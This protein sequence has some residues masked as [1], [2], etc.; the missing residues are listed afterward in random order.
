M[1]VRDVG[2][3]EVLKSTLVLQVE[4]EPIGQ[5][6]LILVERDRGREKTKK[7]RTPA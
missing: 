7:R 5:F 1:R 4:I 2:S 3:F 6:V